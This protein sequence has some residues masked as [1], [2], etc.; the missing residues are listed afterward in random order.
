MKFTVNTPF[1]FMGIVRRENSTLEIP[2]EDLF[3][4]IAQGKK[5]NGRYFSG[6]LN[7]CT[8]DTE[9]ADFIYETELGKPAPPKAPEKKEPTEDEIAAE[10]AEVRAEFDRI[11]KAYHHLWGLP[12]L[13]SELIKAKKET[14]E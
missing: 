1:Q 9:A 11:G 8:P 5:P 7:H 13:K 2:K 3:K 4:E 6:L 10:I 12:R 14:G